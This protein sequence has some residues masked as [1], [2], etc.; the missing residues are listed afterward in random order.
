MSPLRPLPEKS[1]R[2]SIPIPILE[3]ELRTTC[4]PAPDVESTSEELR[5]MPGIDKPDMRF[6]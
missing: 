5:A 1:P 2:V 3:E 6:S 4:S